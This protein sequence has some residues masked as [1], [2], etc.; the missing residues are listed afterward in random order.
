[1]QLMLAAYVTYLQPFGRFIRQPRPSIQLPPA[2]K[3]ANELPPLPPPPLSAAT[4][5]ALK[6]DD[7]AYVAIV[8]M[9]K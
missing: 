1:M 6:E 2:F 8:L 5:T 7:Q 4:S 9:S 3:R